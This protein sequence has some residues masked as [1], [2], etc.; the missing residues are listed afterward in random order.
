MCT[1]LRE[2]AGAGRGRRREHVTVKGRRW[3]GTGPAGVVRVR[4][5]WLC[6]LLLFL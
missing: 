6:C 2:A 1:V 4:W 3:C 5:L